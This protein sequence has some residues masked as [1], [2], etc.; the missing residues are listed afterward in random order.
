MPFLMITLAQP[1]FSGRR[2]KWRVCV[3]PSESACKLNAST[4]EGRAARL[5]VEYVRGTQH[6]AER[7]GERLFTIWRRMHA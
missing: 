4:R 6:D 7:A 2:A 3:G 5:L 1:G